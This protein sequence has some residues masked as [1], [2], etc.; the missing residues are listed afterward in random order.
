MEVIKKSGI[1]MKPR[2]Y[3]AAVAGLFALG[4]LIVLSVLLYAASLSIF[5]LQES[6]VWFAP[7]FGAHGW[8]VLIGSIPLSH[9]IFIA[10]CVVLLEA[11]IRRYAVVYRHPIVGSLFVITVLI[12][13]GGM[14]IAQ[15]SFHHQMAFYAR[16]HHLPPPLATPYGPSFRIARPSGM[17]EGT[18]VS[19][20][21][22]GF[23]MSFKND[24]DEDG[25]DDTASTSHIVITP[26]TRLP[27]G[28]D[29]DVGATVVVEGGRVATD[30][31][32]AFGVRSIDTR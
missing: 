23:V 14:I 19:M 22:G 18:I 10:I 7:S 25:D 16:G 32:H 29:F 8:L 24:G 21:K 1:H 4:V 17:Y 5:L 11:L 3:F 15:T 26:R 27:Y 13:A 20:E 6:G 30:T 28:A 31:I 12:V 2:W 9:V